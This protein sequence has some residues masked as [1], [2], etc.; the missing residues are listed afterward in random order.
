MIE[1]IFLY[2][3]PS[4]LIIDNHSRLRIFPHIDFKIVVPVEQFL[5]LKTR[6]TQIN[7]YLKERRYYIVMDVNGQLEVFHKKLISS[8]LCRY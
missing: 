5:L 3:L 2:K 7:S 8:R 1:T 4:G 6:I